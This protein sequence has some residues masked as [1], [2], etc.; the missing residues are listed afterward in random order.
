MGRSKDEHQIQ[1]AIVEYLRILHFLVFAVPNGGSRHPA[2]AANLKRE[3]VLAGTA[4]LI[5]VLQSKVVF[6]EIKTEKGFQSDSQ[7]KF[8]KDIESLHHEYLIWRSLDDAIAWNKDQR[9]LLT[10]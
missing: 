10:L 4:D 5:L 7:E 8:Q 2:E 1:C 6:I 3:G 9:N